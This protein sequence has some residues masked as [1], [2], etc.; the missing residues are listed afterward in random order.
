MYLGK[1]AE[2]TDRER[3]YKSPCILTRKLSVGGPI[4]NPI[5][6]RERFKNRVILEGDVPSPGQS[7]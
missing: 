5:A 7:A 3:L 4:P 1:L 6:E 2:L